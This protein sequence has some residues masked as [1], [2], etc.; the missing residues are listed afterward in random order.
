M[1]QPGTLIRAWNKIDGKAEVGPAERPKVVQSSYAKTPSRAFMKGAVQDR[2]AK[3][4][5][6]RGSSAKPSQ[7]L[8]I[9]PGIVPEGVQRFSQLGADSMAD[10]MP[11]VDHFLGSS[12]MLKLRRVLNHLFLDHG[13]QRLGALCFSGLDP[14]R[15]FKISHRDLHSP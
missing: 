2:T 11:E 15:D 5:S 10:E 13:E 6:R 14:A 9:A 3:L 1:P 12:D 8:N 7:D 4:F